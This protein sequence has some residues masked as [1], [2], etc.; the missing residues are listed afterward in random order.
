MRLLPRRLG[1]AALLALAFLAAASGWVLRPDLIR[2]LRGQPTADDALIASVLAVIRE[3]Y[4]D[5]LGERDLRLRAVEGIL[6]SLPDKYSSLLREGELKGYTEILEGT[7]GDVGIRLLEG[8]LGLVVQE[9]AAGSPAGLRGIRSGD[10]ILAIED[11]PAL[12]WSALRGEQA[13]RGEPGSAIRIKLRHPGEPEAVTTVVRRARAQRP[14]PVTRV[15]GPGIGYVRLASL[16][17][18]TA[19][20]VT[21]AVNRMVAQGA[22]AVVLDLRNNPGGLLSEATALLDRFLDRGA[23]IGSVEG[24][25]TPKIQRIVATN[26][27]RWP[28]LKVVVLVNAATASAAEIV[29]AGLME[30]GRGTVIGEHTFGKGLVQSTVKL[31][32]ATA[33]RISTARWITP[34]GRALNGGRGARG[35]VEP[36]LAVPP[37][38]PSAG[39]SALIAAVGRRADEFR[40]VLEAAIARREWAPS[41]PKNDSTLTRSPEFRRLARRLRAAGFTLTADQLVQGEALLRQEYAVLVAA[42]GTLRIAAPEQPVLPDAQLLAA[43][44]WLAGSRESGMGSGEWGKSASRTDE[45]GR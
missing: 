22:R 21:S 32:S 3:H 40:R 30:N 12:G 26:D 11:A 16:T 34:G 23:V 15:L 37:W 10:R 42:Q 5:S 38:R 36:N 7:S 14:A 43:V 31:D 29:A 18:G 1:R 13:L 2:A 19:D 6:R 17:R 28:K 24:R 33:V 44:K 41:V 9:V 39:D 20:A 25:G 4:A 8:P 35:G 27:Q 45:A